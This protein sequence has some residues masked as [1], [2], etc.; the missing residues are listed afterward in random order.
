MTQEYCSQSN[1]WTDVEI[2]GFVE[3]IKAYSDILWDGFALDEFSNKFV[4]RSIETKPGDNF[5]A[6][7]Y[8]DGMAR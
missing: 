1:N 8:S 4:V 7:W 6:R 3:A 2:N 5:R